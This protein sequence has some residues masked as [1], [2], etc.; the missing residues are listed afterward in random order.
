MIK[1]QAVL[2]LTFVFLLSACSQATLAQQEKSPQ[3]S[4]VRLKQ[5]SGFFKDSH[6]RVFR[7]VASAPENEGVTQADEQAREEL[8]RLLRQY[9]TAASKH[10]L[11]S[12]SRAGETVND[13]S[14]THDIEQLT[15]NNVPGIPIIARWTDQSSALLWSVAELDLQRLVAA[16]SQAQDITPGFRTYLNQ[17]N[18]RLFDQLSGDKK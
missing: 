3:D 7:G 18:Q 2:C 13:L 1:S 5:D 11:A 12:A 10:Y 8:Q 4:A 15:R 17:Q 6:H 9:F 16:I 14:L